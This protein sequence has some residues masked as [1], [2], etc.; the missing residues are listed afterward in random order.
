MIGILDGDDRFP[1]RGVLVAQIVRELLFG[2][3]GTDQENL[4][5]A[6]EGVND[7]VKEVWIGGRFVTAVRALAAVHTLVLVVSMNHGARLF[8]G[9]ELPGGRLL[10]VDPNDSMKM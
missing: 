3:R 7:F 8:G 4:M 6:I 9:C 5:Y 2:L 1:Q 10:M